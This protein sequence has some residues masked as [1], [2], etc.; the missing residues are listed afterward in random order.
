MGNVFNIRTHLVVQD[1]APLAQ[2]DV[3]EPAQRVQCQLGRVPPRAAAPAVERSAELLVPR[4]QLG[5]AIGG[6]R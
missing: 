2:A 5:P 3:V 6:T 4:P 1:G